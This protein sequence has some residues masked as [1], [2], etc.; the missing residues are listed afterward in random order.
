M[1][2]TAEE[3]LAKAR[4]AGARYIVYSRLEASM[5]RG[6]ESLS[7]PQVLPADFTLVYRH[8]PTETLVYEIARTGN[9]A[10]R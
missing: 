2:Q 5:W 1:A 6:L 10:S 7:D 8:G 4:Q 3:F 9:G